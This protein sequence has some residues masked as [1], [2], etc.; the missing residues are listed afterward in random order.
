[1]LALARSMLALGCAVVLRAA[2][3]TARLVRGRRRSA[4]VSAALRR[5]RV[6]TVAKVAVR[7]LVLQRVSLD[8]A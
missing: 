4:C 7:W 8:I 3:L 1:V 2:V 5:G 6:V